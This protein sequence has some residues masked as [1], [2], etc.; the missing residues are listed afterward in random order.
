LK[1]K[2]KKEVIPAIVAP[3]KRMELRIIINKPCTASDKEG[4]ENHSS[5]QLGSRDCRCEDRIF[6]VSASC[7]TISKPDSLSSSETGVYPRIR[8]CKMHLS[9]WARCQEAIGGI[10]FT[11]TWRAETLE[12]GLEVD[13]FKPRLESGIFKCISWLNG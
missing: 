7:A 3:W 11:K 8:S 9:E 6:L 5:K 2:R 4:K 13:N 1:T 12:P 10:Y